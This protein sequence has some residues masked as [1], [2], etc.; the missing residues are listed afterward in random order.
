MAVDASPPGPDQPAARR[1]HAWLQAWGWPGPL[2]GGTDV[3]HAVSQFGQLLDRLQR[4]AAATDASALALLRQLCN[5]TTIVL[6]GGVLSPVQVISPEDAVGQ[7]VEAAWVANMHD[8]NWPAQPR[9]NPFLPGQAAQRIPRSSAAGELAFCQRLTARLRSIAPEVRFSWSRQSDDVPNA[10]SALLQHL[11]SV[12]QPAEPSAAFSSFTAPGSAGLNGYHR[13]PW[14]VPVQDRQGL[15]LQPAQ[16]GQPAEPM[17]GG[18]GMLSEQ[19][20]CPMM[21]YLHYRLNARFEAMPS[22]FA[23]S[24]YRGTLMHTAMQALYAGHCGQAGV[25]A[26]THVARAVQH[27]LHAHAA[28]QRLLPVSLRAEQQRLENVLREWLEFER[29]RSGF[30]AERLAEVVR[31]ELLGHG[32]TVKADRVDLLANGTRLI[33]DYKSSS[34]GTGGWASSRLQQ[35]QLP[36]YAVVFQR[37]AATQPGGNRAVGG[38]AL[39]T[40]RKGECALRGIAAT[41]EYC[42]DQI[43]SFDDKRSAFARRFDSWTA[44]LQHWHSGVDALAAEVIAGV[45]DNSLHDPNGLVYAGLDLLLRREEGRAWLLAH[46]APAGSS[47]RG[48]P[49]SDLRADPEQDHG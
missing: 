37:Q 43:K 11:P 42:F 1:L 17:R 19:A 23:D 32:I 47:V 14:L 31:S 21:A 22:P 28:S 2:A 38:I 12:D 9:M 26:A 10:P 7:P 24:A 16:A 25:P 27:A 48:A 5:D 36:L 18:A 34:S 13:H 29:Q 8:G 40:V 20:V 3:A 4:I 46:A 33:I 30:S 6:R 35:A 44:L 39:A 49:G 41:P 45:C 15:P